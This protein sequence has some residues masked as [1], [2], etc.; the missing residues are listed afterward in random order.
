[1]QLTSWSGWRF[2]RDRHRRMRDRRIAGR[3]AS[4][5]YVRADSF[6]RVVLS[7]NTGRKLN[8]RTSGGDP[9]FFGT[10]NRNRGTGPGSTILVIQLA[11]LNQQFPVPNR[12]TQVVRRRGHG[13]AGTTLGTCNRVAFGG[14]VFLDGRLV[15]IHTKHWFV[16]CNRCHWLFFR[17]FLKDHTG[18]CLAIDYYNRIT[19]SN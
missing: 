7:S 15:T 1:M 5:D 3:P 4:S 19:L 14:G 13:V 17:W 8:G 16:C 18:L 12:H 9:L 11:V 10:G 2:S 6:D